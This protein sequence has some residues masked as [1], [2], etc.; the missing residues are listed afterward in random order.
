MKETVKHCN[1]YCSWYID[2][3]VM[4][5]YQYVFSVSMMVFQRSFSGMMA[6]L[7]LVRGP[8]LNEQNI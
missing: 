5:S 7:V 6:L 8:P 2:S 4:V 1:V 3:N